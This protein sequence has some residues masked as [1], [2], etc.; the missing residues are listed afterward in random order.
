MSLKRH[1]PDFAWS[2]NK[3]QPNEIDRY[4]VYST[5]FRAPVISWFG[6]ALGDGTAGDKDLT[7][8]NKLAPYP[9]SV[10]ARFVGASGTTKGTL[11]V[12]GKDQFGVTINETFSLA[13]GSAGTVEGTKVFME[14]SAGSAELGTASGSVVVAAGTSGTTTLLGLPIK[15]AGS[16]DLKLLTWSLGDVQ[17]SAGGA[18]GTVDFY[19][20]PAMDAI[21]A[22]GPCSGTVS[23]TAWVKT[24]FDFDVDKVDY[25]N[26]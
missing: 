7:I 21:K 16:T 12:T 8:V 20:V 18:T 22:V 1:Y 23:F 10:E 17:T 4:E 14:I 26:F 2:G 3:V 19:A 15:I 13:S 5:S 11:T 9:T 25:S 6:T 24:S